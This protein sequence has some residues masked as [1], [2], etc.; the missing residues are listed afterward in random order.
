MGSFKY[1]NG[2]FY[3]LR[4]VS[5]VEHPVNGN[6]EPDTVTTWPV[7]V[8][9][10]IVIDAIMIHIPS[11]VPRDSAARIGIGLW[12]P[13]L[14]TGK[15]V[16]SP[17]LSVRDI[18]I[19]DMDSGYNVI[20]TNSLAIVLQGIYRACC[21]TSASSALSTVGG[22]DVDRYR[23]ADDGHSGVDWGTEVRSIVS[24]WRSIPY[25]TDPPSFSGSEVWN[26]HV[27]PNSIRGYL[28]H[29]PLHPWVL[30]RMIPA[31]EMEAITPPL[32]QFQRNDPFNAPRASGRVANSPTSRQYSIRRGKNT[33]L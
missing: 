28:E 21:W 10:P 27:S 32:R 5:G 33:Y 12:R 8:D 9:A 18:P 23:Y 22:S 30:W 2:S 24:R 26:E 4:P 13:S 25:T 15:P 20:E 14:S 17:L 3:G 16:G 1:V 29:S 31:P 19:G 11:S 7:V 6:I